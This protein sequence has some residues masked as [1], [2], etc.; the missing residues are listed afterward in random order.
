M[1]KLKNNKRGYFNIFTW[2]DEIASLRKSD[3][4]ETY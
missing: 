1:A 3:I 2:W 4:L